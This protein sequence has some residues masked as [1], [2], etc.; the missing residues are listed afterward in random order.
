MSKRY[1]KSSRGYIPSNFGLTRNE[2]D[3]IR[4]IFGIIKT[5]VYILIGTFK[6][7]C[8]IYSYFRKL[9]INQRELKAIGYDLDK[10]IDLV[11]TISPRQFEVFI[12]ELFHQHGYKSQL[13]PPENDFGRDVI[14]NDNIFV[15]CKHYSEDN[16]VGREICQKLLGS[17]Q[18]FK[19][20]KGIIVTTG[21]YHRN[22]YEV[23][24][25]VDN[26]Q[27]MDITDLK[28]MILDLKADQISKVIKCTLNAS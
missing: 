8:K 9:M 27:L 14:L 23:A 2:R 13:T 7:I 11:H 24:A 18:M 16:Y 12:C 25:K 3:V 1:Y 22:A 4:L 19:A 21:P 10:I 20:K 28:K 15:E 6:S 26:L 17:M 5:I